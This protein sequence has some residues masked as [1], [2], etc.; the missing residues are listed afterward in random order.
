MITAVLLYGELGKRFGKKWMLDIEKPSEVVSAISA[1][2]PTFRRHVAVVMREYEF[3]VTVGAEQIQEAQLHFPHVGRTIT[4]TPILSGSA[5]G[6]SWLYLIGGV[7]LTAIGIVTQQYWL[8][9]FGL[10]LA[11]G[12]VAQLLS[13]VPKAPGIGNDQQARQSYQ[14]TNVQNT[15]DRDSC[16]P[17]LLG[18][19]TWCGSAV[20][21]A[22]YETVD[23]TAGSVNPGPNSNTGPMT[24]ATP[25]HRN[26]LA[27]SFEP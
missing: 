4:I 10:S 6:K 7:A 24:P 14:F 5:E 1:K 8:A 15:S 21:S 22:A 11:L 17:V 26:R 23:I 12:G 20:A 3:G 19:P 13:P 16:V 27:S 25:I 18:G 9:G 2:F